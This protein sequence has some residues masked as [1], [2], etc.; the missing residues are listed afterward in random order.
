M[1]EKMLSRNNLGQIKGT[2][3]VDPLSA[4]WPISRRHFKSNTVNTGAVTNTV[5]NRRG[6]EEECAW[7]AP[8]APFFSPPL[9]CLL[10]RQWGLIIPSF[11]RPNQPE[12]HKGWGTMPPRYT[13][14]F[15]VRFS[16]GRGSRPARS[17]AFFG[18]STLPR[19]LPPIPQD[20]P[21]HQAFRRHYFFC[22]VPL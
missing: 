15:F 21:W 6:V 1:C 12:S 19:V 22:H 17:S 4:R 14:V 10:F 9:V 8:L 11:T 5:I 20:F 16:R 7:E 18:F 2:Q 3:R 13:H